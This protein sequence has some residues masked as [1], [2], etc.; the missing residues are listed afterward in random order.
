MK[1]ILSA[2]AK[3][4]IAAVALTAAFAFSANAQT[5]PGWSYGFVPT[6]AQW[7]Q[8][9]ASKQDYLG[10][11]PLLTTGGTMTGPLILAPSTTGA[12]GLNVAPGVTPTSPNNGDFWSTSAG[13]FGRVNGVTV[14]PFASGS[15]GSFTATSPITVSFPGAGVVNYGCPTCAVVNATNTFT[16]FQ[17]INR[18]AVSITPYAFGDSL[19][20]AGQIDGAIARIQA[21]AFGTNPSFSATY[22]GGT[23]AIPTTATAGTLLAR[24]NAAPWNGAASTGNGGM[25]IRAAETLGVGTMGSTVCFES[26]AIGTTGSASGACQTPIG[27]LVVGTFTGIEPTLP[28]LVIGNSGSGGINS[29]LQA[30]GTAATAILMGATSGGADAKYWDIV[31]SPTG[32]QFRTLSDTFPGPSATV[33][34]QANRGAGIAVSSVSFP[35]SSVIGNQTGGGSSAAFVAS[36]ATAIGYGWQATSGAVDSKNWDAIANA[37]TL[38][39]RAVNDANSVATS[40]LLVARSGTT[41]TG[42]AIPSS[43]LSL[44]NNG[45]ALGTLVF[46]GSSTGTGTLQA[47]AAMG[48]PT[49]VL[50]T[51]SGTFVA[52]ASA[53]LVRNAVTGDVS[54]PTCA[55]SS[56]GGAVTGTAPISVS[57]AGVVSISFGATLA[58]VGGQL[59]TIAHTGD[60]TTA[61]NSFAT[62]IAAN[63]VTYAKFQQVAASSLVGNPTGSLANAQGITLGATLAFSGTAL[64]TGAGTGDVTW[65]ANSF[66]TTL[67]TVATAGT[68]GSSTAI[69]VITINVKG[70]VTSVTTAAV[71]AP[72]GTV[73][74]TTLAANVVSSSLTSV[75]TLTGGATGAGFTVAL[76]TSTITGILPAANHP[77]LTGDITT[78]SGSVVTTLATVN[79]NVGTFGSATQASQVT[80]NAKGL[81][82]AAANVTVTPAIGSITGLGAGVATWAATPSSAN[83]LAAITDET[84]SGAL[85][86][87]TTPTITTAVLNG[88]I[89]GT[90]VATA[91]TASTLVQRDG[92]GN[93]SAGTV[94]ASLTGHASLDLAL[95]G[96]TMTGNLALL[97]TSNTIGQTVMD[98]AKDWASTSATNVMAQFT[99][100]GDPSRFTIRSSGGTSA[101]PTATSGQLGNINFRGY[102]TSGGPSFTSTGVAN[103]SA[104]AIGTFTSADWGTGLGFGVISSGSTSLA[105]KMLLNGS[106]GL[107]VGSAAV[108]FDPGDGAIYTANAAFMLRTKTSLT[109]GA[110]GNVPTLTAGPVTGNPTKWLPYDDAGTTRY[111]PS[112]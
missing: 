92:S 11:P 56:G 58:N 105:T 68:T 95:T 77:A 84:G 27:N 41:V 69:P 55:T 45:L 10:A 76:G 71:V 97:N 85:V 30:R 107:S 8:Q 60:V 75:G 35:N 51:A 90:S 93:F 6:A 79:S 16:A 62:T 32:T 13:F 25:V 61:A 110:T 86:F 33:W 17:A 21:I 34:M 29:A 12:S 72:A 99:S 36:A 3:A 104:M 52:T 103:I 80:V 23:A 57:G 38:N 87:G 73:T 14:G 18:N 88:T 26:T 109:G 42:V 101:S 49:W 96:G 82:T 54:C 65:S 5:S 47:Q 53:P 63:A 108:A 2:F 102:Y 66:A 40:W 43:P 46:N 64:Q 106:G 7:N 9:W 67:A 59:Q 37:T 1:K 20:Y 19:L 81:V 89:T 91:N 48:T 70:L 111:V 28:G 44:G 31:A 100:Y 39:F 4:S 94:T 78:P 22:V 24:F 112:W 15:G 50:P 83:L 98:V 74:G